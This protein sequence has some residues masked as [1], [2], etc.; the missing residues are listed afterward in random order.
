MLGHGDHPE[1]ACRAIGRVP[2]QLVQVAAI[3]T[4]I[5]VV[6]QAVALRGAPFIVALLGAFALL[7]WQPD[8]ARPGQVLLATALAA[9]IVVALA[10]VPWPRLS[11]PTQFLVPLAVL[12]M[13]ALLRHSDGGG[14]SAFTPLILLP[15]LWA[16]VHARRSVLAM[17]VVGVA[18]ALL[19]PL[20][21]AGAPDYPASET[22]ALI[23]WVVVALATALATRGLHERACSF[24]TDSRSDALT[25]LPN[26]RAWDTYLPIELGRACRERRP[27][28]VAMIDL[29]RFKD[30][31]D[32]RGHQAGDRLLENA[33]RVWREEL[34]STDL[35]CPLVSPAGIAR[36]AAMSWSS[37][38]TRRSTRPRSRAET[39]SSA[40]RRRRPTARAS[41]S[42]HALARGRLVPGPCPSRRRSLPRRA[43]RA[44]AGHL[45]GSGFPRKRGEA[46][47][48]RVAGRRRGARRRRHRSYECSRAARFGLRWRS[49]ARPGWSTVR[50]RG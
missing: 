21:V 10:A 44:E 7:E 50:N 35:L 15:V 36:R 38:P 1:A 20:V 39:A 33:A 29:D 40:H 5:R 31:N 2:T 16:A 24:E 49:E 47:R 48:A 14:H 26:R 43:G 22:T 13:V 19:A 17:T 30:Y 34:R 3:D 9:L 41:S 25:R 18:V 37:E 28:S 4:A 6:R 12:V 32:T 23:I 42:S 8:V 27:L 46:C 45:D 11:G